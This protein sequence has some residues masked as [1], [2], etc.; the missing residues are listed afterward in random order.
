M[1]KEHN[2][3]VTVIVKLIAKQWRFRRKCSVFFYFIIIIYKVESIINN[4]ISNKDNLS[5][6]SQLHKQQDTR[7]LIKVGTM[8]V[9]RDTSFC[10]SIPWC[11]VHV[12]KCIEGLCSSLQLFPSSSFLKKPLLVRH[13]NSP[14]SSHHGCSRL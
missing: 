3:P 4:H 14:L 11:Q 8:G 1:F 7:E 10:Y 6:W 13:F 2:F 5:L 9:A 12:Y